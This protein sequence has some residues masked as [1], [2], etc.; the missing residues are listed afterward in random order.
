MKLRSLFLVAAGTLLLTAALIPRANAD[1]LF[2]YFNFE[3]PPDTGGR[4]AS[5]DNYSDA[6]PGTPGALDATNT[7]GGTQFSILTL[8]GGA[9]TTD[10][11]L[12]LNRSTTARAPTNDQDTANPGSA[13]TYNH[14]SQ[15]P[16]PSISFTADTNLLIDLSLSM[17]IDN[18]G[19]GYNTVTL[20]YTN[21]L[22][23]NFNGGSLT[24]PNATVN[25]YTF[26][27]APANFPGDGTAGTTTFT[28]TFSGGQSNGN[29][30]QF[31]IDNIQLYGTAVPEPATVVGGL[32]GLCGLC[33]HQR[34]R[35]IRLTPLRLRRT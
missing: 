4:N 25:V 6:L 16:N 28:L 34:R 33:W 8:N 26:N 10:T 24:I 13:L 7:G 19:N 2:V 15:N 17:A 20:T 30:R 14:A 32:L 12:L 9:F 29:N 3:D 35:L 18:A 23:T 31:V 11:G 22:V 21:N 5:V 27:L 1:Q